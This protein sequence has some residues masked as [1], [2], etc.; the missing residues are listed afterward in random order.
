MFTA[1]VVAYIWSQI[2][3]N[4]FSQKSACVPRVIYASGDR[5]K[6]QTDIH[7]HLDKQRFWKVLRHV[8]VPSSGLDENDIKDAF[9]PGVPLAPF[10]PYWREC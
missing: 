3:Q 6:D 8:F 10:V 9:Y 2:S 7:V 4:T 1:L 5:V